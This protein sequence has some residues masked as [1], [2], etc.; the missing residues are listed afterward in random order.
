MSEVLA[1]RGAARPAPRM[2]EVRRDKPRK[3][4]NPET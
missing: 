3:E 2:H 1:S 4:R